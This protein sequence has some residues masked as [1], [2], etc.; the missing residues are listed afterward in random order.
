MN[1]TKLRDNPDWQDFW[2]GPWVQE[3]EAAL[4]RQLTTSAMTDPHTLG[5]LRGQLQLLREMRDLAAIQA[6]LELEQHIQETAGLT[7]QQKPLSLREQYYLKLQ[8]HLPR[9]N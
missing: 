4:E 1:W 9:I 8:A 3:R 5:R 7:V 6:R 2:T